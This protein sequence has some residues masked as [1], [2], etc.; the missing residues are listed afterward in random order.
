[1]IAFMEY[2]VGQLAKQSG[3][4]VRT[5]HHYEK[6]GLLSPSARTEAGSRLY[7]EADVAILHRILAYQ[8]MGLA[9]KDIAPLLEPG[10]PPLT[11]VLSRQIALVEEQLARQQRLLAMLRRVARRAQ[12]GGPDLTEHL[13]D[14]IA[15]MRTYERYFS[16][17]ELQQMRQVQE[18]MG[19]D[20]V[21]RVKAALAELVPAMRSAMEHGADPRSPEV[22]ALARRW[23]ALGKGFPQDDA[24]R[25]KGRA[26]LA[27]EPALQRRTGLTP[28]LVD[29]I[30]RA[31]DAVKNAAGRQPAAKASRSSR[32]A[33][34]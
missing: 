22:A 8:Q 30:E 11:A 33:A 7:A 6:L 3:L 24:L 18:A 27:N 14:L 10:A 23:A 15:M 34:E 16:D 31:V 9:L 32:R 13:L 2:T 4:T 20:G 1:M 25:D 19:D 26:M 17:D 5:L 12:A 21:Q 29:Y 28:A